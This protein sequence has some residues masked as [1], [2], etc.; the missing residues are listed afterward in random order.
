MANL[1]KV[2]NNNY[3]STNQQI[4]LIGYIDVGADPTNARLG[5]NGA[6][7]ANKSIASDFICKTYNNQE[8][9]RIC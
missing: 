3:F 4:N 5:I 2:H 6:N 1:F 8:I 7:I 9:P